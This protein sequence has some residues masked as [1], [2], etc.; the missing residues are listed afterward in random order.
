MKSGVA[1]HRC[2]NAQVF[3]FVVFFVVFFFVFFVVFFVYGDGGGGGRTCRGTCRGTC[4]GSGGEDIDASNAVRWTNHDGPARLVRQSGLHRPPIA[5]LLGPPVPVPPPSD[6]VPADVC[7]LLL[8][9]RRWARTGMAV[10]VMSVLLAKLLWLLLSMALLP[11][12]RLPRRRMSSIVT[13]HWR[14]TAIFTCRSG[15][16]GG[17]GGGA[18]AEGV[19]L[20]AS[21]G[22]D[23]LGDHDVCI[24]S[25]AQTVAKAVRTVRT[26]EL[27]VGGR[28]ARERSRH[29]G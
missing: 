11:L 8:S 15:G 18:G 16:R 6:E 12:I 2:V 13:M 23:L 10:V 4:S 20:V 14:E 7:G 29:C 9:G 3:F 27:S 5:V 28:G 25:L 22:K 17:G 21:D 19:R 26:E 24:L 1:L